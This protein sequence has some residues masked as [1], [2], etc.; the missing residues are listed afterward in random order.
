MFYNDIILF[1]LN[2]TEVNSTK[3]LIMQQAT[4]Q[5]TQQH[6]SF[7]YNI[8]Q[9]EWLELYFAL[10]NR[11]DYSLSQKQLEQITQ[12]LLQAVAEEAYDC[13]IIPQSTNMF[14]PDI[15]QQ[16]APKVIT[17]EKNSKEDMFACLQQQKFMK[18][19][20]EKLFKAMEQ[21]DT[22]RINQ[23][24]GNQRNRFIPCLFKQ[25][26]F[27]IQ[28]VLQQGKT[29]VLDDAIFSGTT[30][31]AMLYQIEKFKTDSHKLALF[32]KQ[33]T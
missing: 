7:L 20:K 4:I 3:N 15:A 10:K 25:V 30:F 12:D 17:L 21:M 22:I 1:H 18:A 31:L 33:A 2:F 28:Q 9:R 6:F 13:V 19:E 5:N 14:L 24:A 32:S 29:L 8:Q 16:I 23:I 26:G 27:D 11:Y